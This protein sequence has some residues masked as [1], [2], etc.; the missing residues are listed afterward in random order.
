LYGTI[1]NNGSTPLHLAA[2]HSNSVALI[3]ELI[4]IHPPALP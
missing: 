4:Q 1:N 3:K 2:R